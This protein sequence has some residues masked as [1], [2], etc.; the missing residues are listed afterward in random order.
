MLKFE[1]RLDGLLKNQLMNCDYK[2]LQL[3]R[4]GHKGLFIL[5]L[6]Q[7]TPMMMMIGMY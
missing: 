2:E 7:Y 6:L 5:R 1:A 4:C 3:Q